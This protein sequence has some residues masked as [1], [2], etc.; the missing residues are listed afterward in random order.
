MNKHAEKVE[1]EL[2]KPEIY[3][4]KWERQIV[5]VETRLEASELGHAGGL[6]R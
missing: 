1:W 4:T 5:D 6:W 3:T 2:T